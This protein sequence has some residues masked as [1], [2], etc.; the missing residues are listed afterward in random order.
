VFNQSGIF[1][2]IMDL[3][4]YLR[5]VNNLAVDSCGY[6]RD[7]VLDRPF[8]STPWWRGSEDVKAKIRLAT[9]Q[10]L[11]GSVFRE[12]LPYSLADGSQRFVDFA[13]HP[14]LNQSG[15]VMFLPPT[16]IDTPDPKPPPAPLPASHQPLPSLASTA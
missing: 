9:D 7:E 6:T 14:I 1:A 10:A 12:E 4:G 13:I 11:S 2:G 5:E 16:G 15:T 3:K 8:W